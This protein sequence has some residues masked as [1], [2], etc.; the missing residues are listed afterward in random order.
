ML[1]PVQLGFLRTRYP[2]EPLT[3]IRVTKIGWFYLIQKRRSPDIDAL[4]FRK[5]SV[6]FWHQVLVAGPEPFAEKA[7]M[8]LH[9]TSTFSSQFQKK[10]KKNGRRFKLKKIPD[11]KDTTSIETWLLDWTLYSHFWQPHK[12]RVKYFQLMAFFWGVRRLL[13]PQEHMH[14]LS[15]AVGKVGLAGPAGARTC[16]P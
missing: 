11:R 7:V 13:T 12:A 2:T 8:P 4:K 1:G 6:G 14:S 3:F 9:I 15:G 10:N 16:N 5:S